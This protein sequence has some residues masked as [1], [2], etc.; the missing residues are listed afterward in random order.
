MQA[1]DNEDVLVDGKRKPFKKAEL[2]FRDS[3]SEAIMGILK[4]QALS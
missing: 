2:L 1:I 3:F 4:R